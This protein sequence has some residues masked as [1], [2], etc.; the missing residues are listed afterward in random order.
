ML[1]RLF[2]RRI[3]SIATWSC[4]CVE[5]FLFFVIFLSFLL[6]NPLLLEEGVEA[7]FPNVGD[8]LV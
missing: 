7:Y 8:P 4:G 6:G 3:I 5:L 2:K 1:C